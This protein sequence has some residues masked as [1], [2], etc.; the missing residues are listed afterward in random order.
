MKTNLIFYAAAAVLLILF[1][2]TFI[3][4][5]KKIAGDVRKGIRIAIEKGTVKLIVPKMKSTYKLLMGP[6][7][8]ERQRRK[9]EGKLLVLEPLVDE[10][11][12]VIRKQKEVQSVEEAVYFTGYHPKMVPVGKW[13]LFVCY[14]HVK[15]A[16]SAMRKDVISF[17][18]DVDHQ[19][20]PV[21]SH[22]EAWLKFGTK[23]TLIPKAPGL[24]F[25]PPIV[26]C[27]WSDD[28]NR[29]HFYVRG[30][31]E[32]VNR[33]VKGE[34]SAFVGLVQVASLPFTIKFYESKNHPQLSF[35]D[36]DMSH[37]KMYRN[38]IASFALEDS[39]ALHHLLNALVATGDDG[40]INSIL[41]RDQADWLKKSKRLMLSAES[42]QLFWS[43]YSAVCPVVRQEWEFAKQIETQRDGRFV[44]PIY[45]ETPFPVPPPELPSA[46]FAFAPVREMRD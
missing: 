7:E 17:I 35:R 44:R 8:Y 23:I 25:N 9:L 45:W 1:L 19:I 43:Q 42:F 30:K 10:V 3:R 22:K 18:D 37:A 5:R 20:P 21:V 11:K 26:T 13:Q 32:S 14:M 41:Q 4:L 16:V 6:Q 15:S 2:I 28:L 31:R 46:D 24:V 34:L 39:E 12:T 27:W 29:A 40:L 33:E 36:Y 38:I